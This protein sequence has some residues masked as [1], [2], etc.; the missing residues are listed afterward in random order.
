MERN[1]DRDISHV[2]RDA[3]LCQNASIKKQNELLKRELNQLKEIHAN[4]LK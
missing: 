4:S 1:I 3:L 2:E